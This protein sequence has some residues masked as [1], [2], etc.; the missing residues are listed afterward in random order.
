MPFFWKPTD[1]LSGSTVLEVLLEAHA[2]CDEDARYGV[3][4]VVEKLYGIKMFRA[5]EAG[6]EITDAHYAGG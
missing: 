6:E 1:E 2:E 4:Y 5:L 3:E